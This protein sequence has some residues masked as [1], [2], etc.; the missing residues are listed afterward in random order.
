MTAAEKIAALAAAP[1]ETRYR[2]STAAPAKPA[3][4]AAEPDAAGIGLTPP[5]TERQPWRKRIFMLLLYF[6]FE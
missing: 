6:D 2:Q 3:A 1:D 4:D 5:G